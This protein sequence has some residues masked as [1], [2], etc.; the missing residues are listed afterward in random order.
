MTKQE[1]IEK[2]KLLSIDQEDPS[3]EHEKADELLLEYI[4]DKQVRDAFEAIER[5][6]A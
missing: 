4:G 2:L 3:E 5:W 6:Y 1:L